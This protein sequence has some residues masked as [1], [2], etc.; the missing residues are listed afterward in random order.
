[1]SLQR[2]IATVVSI[3][4]ALAALGMAVFIFN[5]VSSASKAALEEEAIQ[6]IAPKSE[7]TDSIVTVQVIPVEN[8]NY[9]GKLFVQ[10]RLRAY[11]KTDLVAEIPGMLKPVSKRF[12]IGTRYQK[13]E[14][15]FEVDDTEARLNLQAQKAQLQTAITQMMP[16]LKIDMPESYANWKSYLDNFNVNSSIRTFPKAISDRESY[17]IAL[18]GIHSQF[19]TIKSAERRLNKYQVRAPFNGIITNVNVGD[20]GYL[21]AGSPLGT[22]MNTAKYEMEAAVPVADLKNIKQGRS[23]QVSSDD[24]GK[25]WRGTVKRIG[26]MI[27]PTTQTA[28]VYIGVSGSG[29]R[30]GQY[31]N[32]AINSRGGTKVAVLP[33]HLVKNNKVHV[34]EDGQLNTKT[35]ELV[36]IEGGNA[37]VGGLADGT[38]VAQGDDLEKL[39]GQ[40]VRIIQ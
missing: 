9:E 38:K 20:S 21:R 25:T 30:E 36:K 40:P 11:D 14:V 32:A 6:T 2:I 7:K 39:I 35:I 1:M 26:D 22:I 4:V 34:V 12:K 37:M 3:I 15:I 10:G 23:V 29:L 27:D 5:N 13:D 19:Y 16:D 24:T 17:F 28:T 33:S 18:K 31:L 8:R